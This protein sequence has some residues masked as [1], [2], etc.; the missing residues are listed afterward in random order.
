MRCCRIAASTPAPPASPAALEPLGAA[1]LDASGAAAPSAALHVAAP[2]VGG[3]EGAGARSAAGLRAPESGEV[4]VDDCVLSH[5]PGARHPSSLSASEAQDAERETET[6]GTP[7]MLSGSC[8]CDTCRHGARAQRRSAPQRT[9]PPGCCEGL[10]EGP[11][12]ERGA[13]RGARR[14][15]RGGRRAAGGAG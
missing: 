6:E 15:A 9:G 14:A 8:C 11:E 5:T 12:T 1:S 10:V 3:A 4:W 13:P 7:L 2:E